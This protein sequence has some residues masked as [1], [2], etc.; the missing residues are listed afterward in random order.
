MHRP[1]V[2]DAIASVLDANSEVGS[3]WTLTFYSLADVLQEVYSDPTTYAVAASTAG[4]LTANSSGRFP[5]AYFKHT[6]DYKAILKDDAGTTVATI[7]P[8]FKAAGFLTSSDLTPYLQ[9]AGGT[10]TGA[11]NFAEGSA[12]TAAATIDLDAATGNLVH[13][14]GSTGISTMTL[15]QGAFRWLVF[16]AAPTLTHSASLLLPGEANIT[17]AAGDAALVV[18]EGSGVT[19]MLYYSLVSG[20]PL[21]EPTEIL[22]AVGDETTAITTGNAKLTFRMPFAM[23]LDAIPR[24]SLTTASSSG[25]PTVDINEAGASILSTKLT[26]DA[27]ELT[28][29]TAATPAVLSDTSLADDAIITIDIDVAGTNA[30]GLK[31]L[32]RGYRRN[33]S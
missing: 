8:I 33:R 28:S 6:L 24:A 30:A 5:L 2:G 14:S 18:G 7:N 15:A 3:G 22:V 20:K 31:V 27:N 16:D 29:T 9:K 1:V 17:P 26:I 23:T 4:V 12:V 19:R 11:L 10:M 25:I 21:I 32:L 13:I